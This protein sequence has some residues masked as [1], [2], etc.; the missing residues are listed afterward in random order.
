MNTYFKDI[1]VGIK[2]F[3]TGLRL[4][5]KHFRNRHELV[6]TLQYPHEKW[7][8]PERK[9]G[10]DFE[11]YNSIR[12]RLHVDISDCIGCQACERAC[13]VDC[14]IIE[15]V[16]PPKGNT[17]DLGL[18]SNDTKKRV[19]VTKF[20]IDMS[21]CMYCNLCTFPCPES[22]IFMVGG[23]N[24]HK[25]EI[26]YEYCDRDSSNLIFQFAVAT[27]SQINQAKVVPVVE[28]PAEEIK[29]EV[30]AEST[31]SPIVLGI[32]DIKVL[33][34]IE[35]RMTRSSAKKAFMVAKKAGKTSEE[36][37]VDIK[38]ALNEIDKLTDDVAKIVEKLTEVNNG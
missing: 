16:K 22:C 21:K 23:P 20:E 24:A 17:M 29:K 18:T 1:S 25:Q 4:T 10:Y 7:P 32:P 19:L 30:K 3:V 26:D 34:E 14:I 15:K 31:K 5:M 8:I 12:S 37:V 28:K 33:G 2:S 6:S 27:D 38:S 11:D 35:D 13:P 9:I 36:F